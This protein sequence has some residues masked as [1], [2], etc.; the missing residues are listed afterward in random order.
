MLPT[1]EIMLHK[2]QNNF[3]LTWA[4]RRLGREQRARARDQ[5]HIRDEG[6]LA[7]RKKMQG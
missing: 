6:Q 2:T 7:C 1:L 4:R 3:S 5:K